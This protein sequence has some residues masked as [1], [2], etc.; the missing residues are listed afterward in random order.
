MPVNIMG[1]RHEWPDRRK[2][3]EEASV[4]NYVSKDVPLLYLQYEIALSGTPV[5]LDMSNNVSIHDP[6]FGKLLK[7]S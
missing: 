7:E 1:I 5:S 2:L 3:V 6:M 4:I